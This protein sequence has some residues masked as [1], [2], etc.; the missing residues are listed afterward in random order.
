MI[1]GAEALTRAGF[2]ITRATL[3]TMAARGGG[4]PYRLFGRIPLYAWDAALAWAEGRLSPPRGSSSEGDSSP[5]PSAEKP[6]CRWRRDA[7]A[8]PAI[9]RAAARLHESA[10]E[11][12]HE[13][14]RC[15]AAAP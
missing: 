14:R 6:A 8:I 9:A 5:D 4:P 13:R 11:P 12:R 15:P 3:A 10:K 2:P 7:A 1:R